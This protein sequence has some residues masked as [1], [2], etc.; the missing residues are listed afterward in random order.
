MSSVLK[1]GRMLINPALRC[2][3]EAKKNINTSSSLLFNLIYTGSHICCHGPTAWD[4]EHCVFQCQPSDL[5]ILC[6]RFQVFF[7]SQTCFL[8]AFI[9]MFL[10][11]LLPFILYCTLY[12][13][14]F[15]L[16]LMRAPWHF[17]F[18]QGLM[19]LILI[20][21][22]F[23]PMI[24]KRSTFAESQIQDCSRHI[25]SILHLPFVIE[26]SQSR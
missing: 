18:L 7:F 23:P 14:V 13:L 6:F 5:F 16:I 8:S 3:L 21:K 19:K 20:L 12:N 11:S 1:V 25:F 24:T 26:A 9:C 15:I 2:N 17:N 4:A 10:M 22:Y